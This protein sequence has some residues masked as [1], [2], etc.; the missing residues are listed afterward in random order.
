M[1]NLTHRKLGKEYDQE[2]DK[3]KQLTEK[4]VINYSASS[5]NGER[6]VLQNI[7]ATTHTMFGNSHSWAL[8]ALFFPSQSPPAPTDM[9]FVRLRFV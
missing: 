9:I 4:P 8:I 2:I 5:V 7:K 1:I 6:W 3:E